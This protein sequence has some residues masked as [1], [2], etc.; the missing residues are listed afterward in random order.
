VKSIDR[1][2][3]PR[4]LDGNDP[5]IIKV[6]GVG[7]GGGNAVNYM[8]EKKIKDVEFVICNTDRQ[9]LHKS[10]IPTKVQLGANLTKG[11]GAGTDANKGREA[12]IES[13]D[14]IEALLGGPT[15]MVFITAGMG[16]GTGTGAAPVIAKAAKDMGKL[17]VAVVTAPY[18]WEGLDKKEQAL[19]G[20]ESN[21]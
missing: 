14:E 9:A 8:F 21:Y 1:L 2:E 18:T 16:G 11:L 19:E 5:S 20:K 7:G 17:T 12:A 4:P 10:P 13:L 15:Q 6:I 3:S